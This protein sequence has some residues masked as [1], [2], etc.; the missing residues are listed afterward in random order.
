MA[1]ATEPRPPSLSPAPG[2][3]AVAM[4]HHP[5]AGLAGL[6]RRLPGGRAALGGLLVAVAVLGVLASSRG[7]DGPPL[8]PYVVASRSLAPGEV[9][10]SGDLSTVAV[11]LPDPL[12][13]AA[14]TDRD[15][16]EGATVLAPFEAGELIQ[17]G[18]VS[19][20]PLPGER[21]LRHE[22]AVVL[23]PAHAGGGPPSPGERV[24][25]IATY[26]SGVDSWTE[27]IAD[28]A[29]V[30]T[31]HADASDTVGSTGG[32]TITLALDDGPV[33]LAVVHAAEAGV[34]TL[35]RGPAEEADR[36]GPRSHRP[37]PPEPAS[38]SPA[39]TAASSSPRAGD[40]G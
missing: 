22:V 36:S 20:S 8:T 37:V 19:V 32:I 1:T 28:D 10:S 16:L 24:E 9:I 33:V 30:L 14:F 25:V 4:E 34:L 15:R 3:G 31:A 6:P 5:P 35:V 39:P 11:H 38:A 12:A 27:V 21:D 17:A 2:S 40:G 18:A 26:G 29:L 13:G 23:D 7:A